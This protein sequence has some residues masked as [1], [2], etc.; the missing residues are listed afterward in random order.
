VRLTATDALLRLGGYP[1]ERQVLID[2]G[3]A[4]TGLIPFGDLLPVIREQR[5]T[6]DPSV[7]EL[8]E[9]AAALGGLL[10]LDAL[11]RVRR[12]IDRGPDRLHETAVSVRAHV[13]TAPL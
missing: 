10:L 13:A 8:R 4:S 12:A 6:G 9:F 5:A 2:W 7:T 3:S 1:A 11:D